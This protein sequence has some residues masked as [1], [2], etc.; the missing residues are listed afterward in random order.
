MDGGYLRTVEVVRKMKLKVGDNYVTM[1]L[2][3]ALCSPDIAS[4]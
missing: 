3:G 2:V 1:S 4:D